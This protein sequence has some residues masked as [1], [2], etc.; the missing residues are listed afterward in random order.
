MKRKDVVGILK[1][2]TTGVIIKNKIFIVIILYS[3]LK[4]L[5]LIMIGTKVCTNFSMNKLAYKEQEL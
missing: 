4:T 1:K 3:K 5:D 2:E